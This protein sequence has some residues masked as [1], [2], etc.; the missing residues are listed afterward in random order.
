MDVIL[1][2]IAGAI[3]FGAIGIIELTFSWLNIT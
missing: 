2:L 3:Y 1:G